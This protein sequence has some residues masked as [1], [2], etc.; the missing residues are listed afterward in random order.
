M[1]QLRKNYKIKMNQPKIKETKLKKLIET[2]N[3]TF[4]KFN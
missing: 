3:I 4:R 2:K 1:T